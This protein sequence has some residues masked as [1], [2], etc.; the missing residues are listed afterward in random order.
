MNKWISIEERL[1]ENDEE[2][3]VWYE[4]LRYDDL[5]HLEQ[6]GIARY[7]TTYNQFVFKDYTECSAAKVLYWMLIPKPPKF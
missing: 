3:L 1:P 7:N 2:V 4:Y 5:K 6:T